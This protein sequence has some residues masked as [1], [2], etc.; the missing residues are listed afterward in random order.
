MNNE[1]LFFSEKITSRL[2]YTLT[3]IVG[4][5]LGVNI[6]FTQDK[7]LFTSAHLPKINYSSSKITDNE[8]II[9][10]HDL[11]FENTVKPYFIDAENDFFSHKIPA[12]NGLLMDAESAL[13]PLIP[14]R[15]EIQQRG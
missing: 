1:I 7:D 3:S 9:K 4:D 12:E 2:R 8:L 5:L 14:L 15:Y 13:N 10:P 6:V 11:L